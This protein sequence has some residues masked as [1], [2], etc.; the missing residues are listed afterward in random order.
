MRL[1]SLRPFIELLLDNAMN[2]CHISDGFSLYDVVLVRG[3]FKKFVQIMT[4]EM[5]RLLHI[6]GP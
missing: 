2:D 3:Y 6:L 5:D 4:K 1:L